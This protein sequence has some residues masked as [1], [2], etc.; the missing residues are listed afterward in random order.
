VLDGILKCSALSLL[1]TNWADIDEI[2]LDVR[3]WKKVESEA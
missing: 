1:E 2:K 3:T